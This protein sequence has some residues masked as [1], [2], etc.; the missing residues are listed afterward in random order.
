MSHRSSRLVRSLLAL[1]PLTLFGLGACAA[2]GGPRPGAAGIG[3]PYYPNSGNGGFDVEHYDLELDVDME[4][5]T[6]AGRAALSATSRVGARHAAPPREGALTLLFL[7]QYPEN[8]AGTKYRLGRWAD[9]LRRGGH[10]VDL[11]VAVPA[12]H[13]ERSAVIPSRTQ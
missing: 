12:P 3:D 10:H 2:S 6:L 4:S 8:F 9:R 11:S 1:F 7:S 5:A 13:G